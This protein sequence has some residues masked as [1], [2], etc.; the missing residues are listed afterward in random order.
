MWCCNEEIQITVLDSKSVKRFDQFSNFIGLYVALQR[1]ILKLGK[2]SP[3]QKNVKIPLTWQHD[4]WLF[5]CQPIYLSHSVAD[6]KT[7]NASFCKIIFK[8]SKVSLCAI[9]RCFRVSSSA[10][11]KGHCLEIVPIFRHTNTYMTF[12]QLTFGISSILNWTA[13]VHKNSP[14]QI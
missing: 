11:S 2:W 13:S 5:H 12:Y 7:D 9:P 4:F 6:S 8:T 10:K 14:P 3:V 1:G